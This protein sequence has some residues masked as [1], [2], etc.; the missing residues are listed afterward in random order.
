MV[1][2]YP[3]SRCHLA[4]GEALLSSA[5]GAPNCHRN[6]QNR[7][8]RFAIPDSPVSATLSRRPNRIVRFLQLRVAASGSCSILVATHF[9]DS[10][11]ES[12]FSGHDSLWDGDLLQQRHHAIL[13]RQ[14]KGTIHKLFIHSS[15]V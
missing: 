3:S 7:T 12:I 5:S 4:R 8:I 6:R 9:G 10:I 14:P 11:G 13:L 1:L 2:A 15:S